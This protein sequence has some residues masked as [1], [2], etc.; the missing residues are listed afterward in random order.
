MV[1]RNCTHVRSD[2]QRVGPHGLTAVKNGVNATENIPFLQGKT[3]K[4]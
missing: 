3:T 1:G 2:R 4:G